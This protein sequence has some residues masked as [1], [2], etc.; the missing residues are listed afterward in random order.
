M[1]LDEFIANDEGVKRFGM[2]PRQEW[3]EAVRAGWNAALDQAIEAIEMYQIPI[4][5]S[6]AGELACDWTYDALKDIR[7]ELRELKSR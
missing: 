1:T 5:N 2:M 6:P 4:G 7:D 3:V